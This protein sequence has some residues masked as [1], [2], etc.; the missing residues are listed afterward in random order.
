MSNRRSLLFATALL[1]GWATAAHAEMQTFFPGTQYALDVYYLQGEKPGPTIM[2]QGGIQGDE[3][4][5]Y[6]T[7]QLLTRAKV[8][9]GALIIVPRANPPSV[10][11]RKRVVNV[12][13]NRRFDR[14]YNEFYEDHLARLVRYLL[15]QSQGL[16]HLHEGSGFYNPVRLDDM[17][18]PK[19]YGQSIVIDTAEYKNVHL[20]QTVRQVLARLNDGL[21]PEK[22]RFKLFNQETFND[23]SH[24]LEQRKSLTYYA[25][26]RLGIPAL[27]IEVSKNLVGPFWSYW[28]VSHQMQAT[29][30]FLRK[31]GVELEAPAVRLEDFQAYPPRDLTVIVNGRTL[32]PANPF[33]TVAPDVPLDVRVQASGQHSPLEPITCVAASDRAGFNML[34]APRLPM[35]PFESLSVTSDGILLSKA[36]LSWTGVSR[37]PPV[38]AAG[39]LLCWLNG[40]L[41]AVAPG[42]TLTAVEGDQLILEGIKGSA[43]RE[44]LNLKGYVSRPGRDDGQ[45][46]GQEIILDPR[47]FLPKYVVRKAQG[48]LLCEVVRETPGVN[49]RTRFSIRIVPREVRGLVLTDP[50]GQTLRLPWTPGK[51]LTLPPGS[52]RLTDIQSNGPAAKIQAFLNKKPVGLGKELVIDGPAELVFR[53][54]TTFTEL[55]AMPIIEPVTLDTAKKLHSTDAT[56]G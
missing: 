56:G 22:Y 41:K 33:A 13:M 44:V 10:N 48:D 27:D 43:R 12:D 26:S 53:Q 6:L 28:K 31:F 16:I 49:P 47:E 8:T 9:R 21:K 15:G 42:Q 1:L 17:H 20:A 25:L 32:D 30:L 50:S 29:V 52:Y 23:R 36:R 34:Q 39:D 55:G 5:G 46:A 3:Y 24:Y 14:D 37:T 54:A 2:I 40:E 35:A 4:C 7:A 51:P 11:I 38:A 45:D 18:S 19:R